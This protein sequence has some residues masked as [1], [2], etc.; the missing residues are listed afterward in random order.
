[1]W[2]EIVLFSHI[3]DT[4]HTKPSFDGEL[5]ILLL[6]A[7]CRRPARLLILILSALCGKI[8]GGGGVVDFFFVRLSVFIHK[9]A[10]NMETFPE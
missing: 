1:M 3:S 10:Q 9:K 6:T 8:Q 5:I 2:N 7:P 4:H